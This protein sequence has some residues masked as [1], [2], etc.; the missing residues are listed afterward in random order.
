MTL[1]SYRF[2]LF[3]FLNL[4]LSKVYILYFIIFRLT[5]TLPLDYILAKFL[6]LANFR[7]LK[8]DGLCFQ[9]QVETFPASLKQ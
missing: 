9:G 7:Q 5:L 3:S 2:L 6:A 8:I 4:F 1:S